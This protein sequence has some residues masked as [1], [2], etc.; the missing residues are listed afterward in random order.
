[1]KTSPETNVSNASA[2][3]ATQPVQETMGAAGSTS[4]AQTYRGMFTEYPCPALGREGDI[5]MGLFSV[6]L[7]MFPTAFIFSITCSATA[8]NA[9][10]AAAGV[11]AVPTGIA[12]G[13][14]PFGLTHCCAGVTHA[15]RASHQSTQEPM[16][17]T[18]LLAG[19]AATI[20]SESG[21]LRM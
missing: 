7:C 10:V 15:W 13:A 16:E 4:Y 21:H 6:M 8:S 17:S 9:A 14:V 3:V 18:R 11:C 5:V 1:M 12:A 19:D 20:R 2:I